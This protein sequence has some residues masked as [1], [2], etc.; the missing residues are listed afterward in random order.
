MNS[1][2]LNN[3]LQKRDTEVCWNK[4]DTKSKASGSYSS[5]HLLGGGNEEMGVVDRVLWNHLARGSRV[6]PPQIGHSDI[7]HP[8][9]DSEPDE[10]KA[11]LGTNQEKD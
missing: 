6:A 7:W 10:E 3:P 2:I 8:L 11:V 1:N 4:E 9:R 5:P